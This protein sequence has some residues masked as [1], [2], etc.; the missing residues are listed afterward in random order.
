[1]KT[2][3]QIRQMRQMS[4]FS[5]SDSK[6][7]LFFFDFLP[8]VS[9]LLCSRQGAFRQRCGAV[10]AQLHDSVLLEASAYVKMVA[11]I[12]N[13]NIASTLSTMTT[14]LQGRVVLRLSCRT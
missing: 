12:S 5:D 1:M 4:G 13:R 2:A 8:V 9:S 11:P 3:G 14:D 10:L 6:T 7:F